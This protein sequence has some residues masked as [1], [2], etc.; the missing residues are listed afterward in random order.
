MPYPFDVAIYKVEEEEG[1]LKE[2]QISLEVSCIY[3]LRYEYD[4]PFRDVILDRFERLLKEALHGH[5]W[6]IYMYEMV[7]QADDAAAAHRAMGRLED[8]L[9]KHPI[10]LQLPEGGRCEA[11]IGFVYAF[12][13]TRD[14]G[15]LAIGAARWGR[16]GEV[17]TLLDLSDGTRVLDDSGRAVLSLR[18]PT[19]EERE[20][21]EIYR[22]SKF[23]MPEGFVM[24]MPGPD[25]VL[26]ELSEEEVAEFIRRT[27]REAEAMAKWI[28]PWKFRM[29]PAAHGKKH[30]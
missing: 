15:D 6:R 4:K 14:E 12:G 8:A 17:Q 29:F 7:A 25:G 24:R 28:R 23:E 19:D 13:A 2:T 22:A 21:N 30:R 3:N 18:H 11:T 5:A 26:R 27:D 1:L 16:E 9:E 10:V 20:Y